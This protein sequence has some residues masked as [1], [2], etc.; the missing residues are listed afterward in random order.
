MPFHSLV[1]SSKGAIE[2]FTKNMASEYAPKIRFNCVAPSLTETPLSR[3]IVSNAKVLE[4][5]IQKHPMKRIGQANDIGKMVNFLLKDDSFTTGQV[6]HV[7]GG[8]SL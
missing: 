8:L 4:A 2:G 6:F 5:S 1:G 3:S 7:D